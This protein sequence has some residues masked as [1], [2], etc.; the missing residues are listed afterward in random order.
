MVGAE[1]CERE[2]GFEVLEFKAHGAKLAPRAQ[3]DVAI[4][5]HMGTARAG[6]RARIVERPVG[7]C[8]VGEAFL[9][10]QADSEAVYLALPQPLLALR[11]HW[12]PQV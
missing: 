7:R 1:A 6:S 4:G 5:A 9:A 12:W 8:L 2:F 10:F 3:A 11:A